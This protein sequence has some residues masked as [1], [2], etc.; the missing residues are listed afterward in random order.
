MEVWIP[1]TLAA[2]FFQNTRSA[3]QK[4]LKGRMGTSGATFARF[5][6][7]FPFA[8]AYV[9]ALNQIA[10]LPMPLWSAAFISYSVIGGASQII[11]TAL[12]IHLFSYRNF[13]VG[14][15]FSKT[16]TVQA[17]LFGLIILGD[18]ISFPALVAIF[19]SLIG[20]IIIS[21]ARPSHQGAKFWVSLTGKPAVLGIASG[22]CFGISAV[23][24][25]AASLS[26][27]ME[28][29]VMSA[30]FTLAVVTVMQTTVMAIYMRI[31]D[32]GEISKVFKAWRISSLVGLTGMIA[33]VGWFT[34]MTLQNAA[35]VR[36]LGQVELIF[37]FIVSIFIFKEH[38]NRAEIIGILF[39]TLGILGLVFYR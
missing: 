25:R 26:L 6:F 13:T 31:R 38:I 4:H 37:T 12:L 27:N 33:S 30:A 32:P 24:Y 29:A 19:I 15:T 22:A 7:A 5:C 14:T 2:A 34:A 28:S 35:Y 11:A 16:E 1:I 18:V 9:F 20:V 36:A 3:L 8:W 10:G 21:T 23:S 17:A 39:V